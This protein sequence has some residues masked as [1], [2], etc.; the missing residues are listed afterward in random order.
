MKERIIMRV[1]KVV[2]VGI[3]L[4]G[5]LL[6]VT[7]LTGKYSLKANIVPV[8]LGVIFVGI[9]LV[10]FFL[11]LKSIPQEQRWIIE[12]FGSYYTTKG[13]GLTWICP[14]FMKVREAVS[15]W[16]Q[17][18]QLFEKPIKIDFKDGSAVP[19]EGYVFVQCNIDED[20]E[21][22]YKMVYGVK[23]VKGAVVA[24]IENA[25]RSYLNSLD[26]QTGIE[27][28]KA[29]YDLLEKIPS[30]ARDGI[31][32]K[33]RDWGLRLSRVTIGD[34]DLD[35]VV[36]KAR[37]A[38]LEAQRAAKAA[39]SRMVQ[40]AYETAGSHKEIVKILTGLNYT[41]EE[42]FNLASEYIKYWRGSEKGVIQ[43]WRFG[44]EGGGP[45]TEIAK[46]IAVIEAAKK[47][48]KGGDKE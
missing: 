33:L 32:Q 41:P 6:L 48:A 39:E 37:E 46:I 26:L 11:G 27:A 15:V 28:G 1:V 5:I 14:I 10:F 24:L 29:G 18:Y 25:L 23:N 34:F 2:L 44:G 31:E 12:V 9:P 21:A 17:R 43:D 45:Y 35:E 3:E 42:A 4:L 13:P 19:K 40:I 8:V 36:I 20:P 30:D 16:E 47:V 7:F 38:V 22:P